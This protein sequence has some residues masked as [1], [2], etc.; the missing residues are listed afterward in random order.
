MVY[1]IKFFYNLI[2]FFAVIFF[3]PVWYFLN[4]KKGYK[5]GL[6]ERFVL[7]TKKLDYQPV[8]IHCASTGE[9]NTALPI[10]EYIKSKEKVLL[11][12]FSPRAYNFAVNNLKDIPVM[13]LPFDFGFLIKRFLKVYN[14]KLLIIEE[15]EFWFNFIYHT[16]KKIP[17]ISINTK[18]PKKVNSIYY[19]ETLKRFSFFI[20]RTQEDKQLLKS[21]VKEDKIA[22]CGNLKLLSKV[23]LKQVKLDKK[24]KK[25]ILAGSTHHPEEEILIKVFKQIKE[26]Y[27]NTCLIIAPRH[28]ERVNDI[29]Q[30]IENHNLSYS[31]RSKTYTLDSDVYIMDTLG[32]LSSLYKYGDVIFVGG[33]F[34][35]VGGHNIFEPILTGKKV[36]IGK[37]YFKIKDLVLQAQKMGAVVVVEDQNQLKNAILDLLKDSK[38]NVDIEQIKTDIYNCYKKELEKWI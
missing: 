16:S 19:R 11:T 21:I 12:V 37:N 20:V 14:P 2:L 32:E 24:D 34:S 35:K 29:I 7:R 25:V 31:L 5:V 18:L 38:L 36:I 15:A 8:W 28:I 26:I 4:A 10:I 9:I 23:N 33:T 27:P 3:V 17:V 6:L 1:L 13:F 30:I 22:V